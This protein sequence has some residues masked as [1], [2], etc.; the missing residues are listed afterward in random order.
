MLFVLVQTLVVNVGTSTNIGCRVGTSTKM[1]V[2]DQHV[3]VG[4]RQHWLSCL[5]STNIGCRVGTST[6]GCHVGL[7]QRLVVVLLVQT[8][9]VVLV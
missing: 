6:I 9:V 8:L 1:F 7:V 4:T 3:N 2:L 5:S